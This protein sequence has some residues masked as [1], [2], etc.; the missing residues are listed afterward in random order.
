MFLALLQRAPLASRLTRKAGWL[1]GQGGGQAAGRAGERRA[2]AGG[3]AG[4]PTAYSLNIRNSIRNSIRN[5]YFLYS[6]FEFLSDEKKK[7]CI[8]L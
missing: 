3:Q 2:D 7:Y 5:I 6:Q 1:G 4:G 8:S